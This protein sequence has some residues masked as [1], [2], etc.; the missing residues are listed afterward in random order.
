MANDAEYR[1]LPFDEAI[2][3]FRGKL[4]IPSARWDDLW[5]GMHAR[6]FMIAGAAKDELLADFRAAVDKAIAGGESLGAF[7]RRFDSIV[8]QHG[9]DYRGGRNWR[10]E[11]IYATNVRTAY[12]AGRYAQM[13]DPDTLRFMPYWQYQHGDSVHPRPLH[14]SWDGT[15]L[16][17]NDPWFRTHFAP[18]GWGCKCSIVPLTRRDLARLG[19]DGPDKA[20]DDGTYT[21]TDQA[22]KTHTI[23]KGIDPGWDYNVGEAAWG[24]NQAARAMEDQ[25]PW[26]DLSPKGPGDYGRPNRIAVDPPVAAFGHPIPKGDVSRL[27]RALR[28]AIGGDEATMIDPTGTR[29]MVTQA[30]TDHIAAK[31]DRRWDGREAYFPF[32]RELI[33]DPYEI[34]VSFAESEASG[35]VG[36]RRKYVKAIQLD[37]D[38]V[39]GLYAEFMNGQWVSGDLFRGG[40]TGA[41]NLRKGRMLYER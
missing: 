18:N 17:A 35:R 2:A 34:W 9:W 39:L 23:P 24:R 6:G 7:R 11:V 26:R 16:P 37:R 38:R 15:V 1:S 12:M 13:T 8:V 4:N 32:I 3:F 14:L 33:E 29:V 19:K 27:Q 40:L 36:I 28:D 22:G 25:G 41:G 30:I 20:P 5:Q 21:W 10:S 31:P